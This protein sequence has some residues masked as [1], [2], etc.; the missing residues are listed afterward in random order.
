MIKYNGNGIKRW[1]G[2][3]LCSRQRAACRLVFICLILIYVDI[4]ADRQ[5]DVSRVKV[6]DQ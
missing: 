5:S 3:L 1:D 4:G 2:M 6:G